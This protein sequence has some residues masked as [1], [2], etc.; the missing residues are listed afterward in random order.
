MWPWSMTWGGGSPSTLFHTPCPD[1]CLL[2]AGW[3]LDA[4]F[5]LSTWRE[6]LRGA[7]CTVVGGGG[8]PVGMQSIL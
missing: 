4:P 3:Q 2:H 7:G 5:S 8:H 1:H 6:A